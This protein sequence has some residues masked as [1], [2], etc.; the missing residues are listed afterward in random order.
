[1]KVP[2]TWDPVEMPHCT[3]MIAIF[4][5]ADSLKDRDNHAAA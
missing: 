4:I 3:V 5:E 1:M 2:K